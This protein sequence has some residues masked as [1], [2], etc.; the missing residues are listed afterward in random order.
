MHTNLSFCAPKETTVISFLPTCEQYGIKTIGISNH[1]YAPDK[2]GCVYPEN[3]NHT[4][5]VKQEINA[6][7]PHSKINFLLG[8]EIE[9]FYG[10]PPGV[11]KEDA[12]NFDYLLLAPSHIFNFPEEY[13]EVDL[14]SPRKVKLLL[15]KQFV[16]ACLL[17]YERPVGICHPLYPIGC[18]WE[19]MVIDSFLD[20]EY[21]TC[22]RLAAEHKISIEVHACLARGGTRLDE[23]GLSPAYL[24]MLE[25]AKSCG[26]KFHFGSD[27][28]TPSGL[29]NIY[30]K[31]ELAAKKV[32][33]TK[34]DLWGIMY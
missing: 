19:Q 20:S 12:A 32:G 9:T 11:S 8:C 25:I 1:I 5:K 10:Q 27:A 31:L 29:T 21:E 2:L 7:A 6:F 34:A 13:R 28:H 33:I 24:H 17:E 23:N 3:L 15:I 30:S 22:F 4:L 26:C 14:S 16:R 18:P